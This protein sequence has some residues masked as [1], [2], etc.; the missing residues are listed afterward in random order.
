MGASA[1]SVMELKIATR[2]VE[3]ARETLGLTNAEVGVV[4]GASER[5]V[6]RWS[7]QAHPPRRE[8]RDRI[9]KLNELRHLLSSVFGDDGDALREW[10]HEPVPALRGRAPLSLVAKG[11]LDDVIGMLAGLESGA[12]I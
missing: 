8:H 6:I 10:L 2:A 7:Q 4:L 1:R 3:W 12:F 11:E 5:T 9:E